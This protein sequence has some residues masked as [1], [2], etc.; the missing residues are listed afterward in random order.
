MDTQKLRVW[1]GAAFTAT[2]THTCSHMHTHTR[3]HTHAPTLTP[4]PTHMH[5]HTRM[6]LQ[7]VGEVRLRWLP[8]DG[9][10]LSVPSKPVSE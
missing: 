3:A 6:N 1:V 9:L 8:P 7:H 5:T 2:N 10:T 4:T